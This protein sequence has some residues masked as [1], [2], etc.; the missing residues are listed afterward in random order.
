VSKSPEQPPKT[1]AARVPRDVRRTQLLQA[2]HEIFVKNGYHGASMDEIAEAAHVSKPVVYQHF[3][4]K[5]ELYLALLDQHLDTLAQLLVAALISTEDNEA[6]VRATV[7]AYFEFVSNERNAHR[8]IF[9]SDV[10]SEPRI[11][12]RLDAFHARFSDAIT[13]IIVDDGSF[14]RNQAQLLAR[15][16]AGAAQFSARMWVEQDEEDRVDLETAIQLIT[17]LAWRGI[18]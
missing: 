1:R 9:E 16:L 15:G 10:A 2:A 14:P 7:A 12:K 6:R 3:A 18:S 13:D 5:K 8:L 17:D 11:A 4:G